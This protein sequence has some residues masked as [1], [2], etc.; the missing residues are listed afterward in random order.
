M[1]TKSTRSLRPLMAI[2]KLT[3]AC[4]SVAVYRSSGGEP[5]GEVDRVHV[6]CWLLDG[7]P[8]VPGCWWLTDI[9]AGRRRGGQG[10]ARQAEAAAVRCERRHSL[11]TPPLPSRRFA[12]PAP[13]GA[14]QAGGAPH[15]TRRARHGHADVWG[16]DGPGSAFGARV[17]CS[18]IT[19]FQSLSLDRTTWCMRPVV[20]SRLLGRP[21]DGSVTGPVVGLACWRRL[22]DLVDHRRRCRS[23]SA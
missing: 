11:T 8:G 12:R 1:S 18:L 15:G 23:D 21:D 5:T 10:T 22:A 14:C 7:G 3:T 16:A 6:H 13:N 4:P 2:R 17:R 9:S 19:G 20:R